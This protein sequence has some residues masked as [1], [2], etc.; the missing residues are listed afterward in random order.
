MVATLLRLLPLFHQALAVGKGNPTLHCVVL[1]TPNT[2]EVHMLAG[3][4]R[5]KAGIFECDSY[6]IYS[7]V[8]AG[9]LF[10]DHVDVASQL[11]HKVHNIGIP[12]FAP[13]V[14][15]P[16]GWDPSD[17][18]QTGKKG[19][20]HLAN[21]PIFE[22]LWSNVC[23]DGDF[24]HYSYTAKVDV[25]T[26]LLPGRVSA[27]M[28]GRPQRAE[29]F[30]NVKNDMYGNFLHGP[31]ELISRQAMQTLCKRSQ[32]CKKSISQAAYGED[33]YMN[34]CLKHLGVP[35]VQ[36]V[37]LLYDMYTY[38]A[39]GQKKCTPLVAD[40]MVSTVPR[41]Y[42]SY[43]PRKDLASWIQ[44]RREANSGKVL[45]NQEVTQALRESKLR[46]VHSAHRSVENF[47]QAVEVTSTRL[48]TTLTTTRPV[49]IGVLLVGS[50]TVALFLLLRSPVFC[51]ESSELQ[52]TR[53]PLPTGEAPDVEWTEV[54]LT[55]RSD[56]ERLPLV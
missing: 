20:K 48:G 9:E 16:P 39:W 12:L 3:Q 29:Y 13:M 21:T 55:Y 49:T 42:A 8:S 6:D 38:G 37:H 11:A 44:C 51:R 45:T 1:A 35:A 40:K 24:R 7:N 43:H 54:P 56:V 5:L 53:V 25:D 14:A 52:D 46:E 33:F 30:W 47:A 50:T 17:S 34:E 23:A 4:F 18:K 28:H 32:V 15:G 22:T 10:K 2:Y 27:D 31:I 19:A 41:S 36:G 26:V